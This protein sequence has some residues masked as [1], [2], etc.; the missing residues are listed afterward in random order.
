MLM[1]DDINESAKPLLRYGINVV[2][3]HLTNYVLFNVNIVNINI[4]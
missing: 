2:V 4:T 3:S 1:I